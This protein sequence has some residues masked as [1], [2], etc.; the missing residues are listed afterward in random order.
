MKN[1]GKY[2]HQLFYI[3][4]TLLFI[5]STI[6]AICGKSSGTTLG[7]GSLC[8]ML[9]VMYSERSK[10]NKDTDTKDTENKDPENKDNK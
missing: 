8:L 1:K 10:A 9:G 7:L 6:S 5:A 3:A 2:I 4:A